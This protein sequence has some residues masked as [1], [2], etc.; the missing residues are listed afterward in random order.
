[1]TEPQ[2]RREHRIGKDRAVRK[3][4]HRLLGGIGLEALKRQGGGL[5]QDDNPPMPRT[6]CK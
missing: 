3:P 4:W 6:A 5:L 1:M 2:P